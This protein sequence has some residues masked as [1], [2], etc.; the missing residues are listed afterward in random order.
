MASPASPEE[1]S[2]K[3]R[4]TTATT[5][6][7][8]QQ[9]LQA[10]FDKLQALEDKEQAIAKAQVPYLGFPFSFPPTQKN[11]GHRTGAGHLEV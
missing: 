2:V 11:A 3:K 8:T 6:N 1:D 9:V 10:A 5:T 4:P 7:L